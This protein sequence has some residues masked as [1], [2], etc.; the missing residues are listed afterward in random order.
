MVGGYAFLCQHDKLLYENDTVQILNITYLMIEEK[1]MDYGSYLSR[2][3][4]STEVQPH[5]LGLISTRLASR[6][7]KEAEQYSTGR[8]AETRKNL[9]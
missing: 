5:T 6:C 9:F 1:K 2:A 7:T 8:S 3:V 4:I